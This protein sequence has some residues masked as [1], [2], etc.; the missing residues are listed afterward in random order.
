MSRG[1]VVVVV[2]DEPDLRGV[3]CE[4]LED[5]G[6]DVISVAH[7][8]QALDLEPEPM[9]ALFLVDLMLPGMTGIELAERIRASP[10]HGAPLIAISASAVMLRLAAESGLFATTMQKPF[11][12]DELLT[13]VQ[14]YAA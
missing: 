6:Y 1:T 2:D 12:I 9:P 3:L 10:F 11:D 8:S 7:P 4:V 13:S 14:Q 5:E